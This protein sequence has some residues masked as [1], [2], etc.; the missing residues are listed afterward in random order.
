MN[1]QPAKPRSRKQL[2]AVIAI[3]LLLPAGVV[4]VGLF[5]ARTLQRQAESMLDHKQLTNIHQAMVVWARTDMQS[6]SGALM[7]PAPA[8]NVTDDAEQPDPSASPPGDG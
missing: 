4:I 3:L 7:R 6:T 2:V 1:D 5:A 8:D